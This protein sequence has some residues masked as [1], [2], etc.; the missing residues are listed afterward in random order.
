MAVKEIIATCFF[1]VLFCFSKKEPKKEPDKG[2]HPL[3]RKQLCSAVVLLWLQHLIFTLRG[4]QYNLI[5]TVVNSG[6][7]IGSM[8]LLDKINMPQKHSKM[9]YVLKT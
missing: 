9:T 3:C 5:K 8:G 6:L 7:S 1:I 2:L 4:S